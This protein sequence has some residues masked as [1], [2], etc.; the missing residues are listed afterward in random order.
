MIPQT[1]DLKPWVGYIS[2]LHPDLTE[3]FLNDAAQIYPYQRAHQYCCLVILP[4]FWQ[5]AINSIAHHIERPSP[6]GTQKG[7]RHALEAPPEYCLSSA[8]RI[9]LMSSVARTT[10]HGIH[11]DY[12]KQK[13]KNQSFEHWFEHNSLF[14]ETENEDFRELLRLTY[15]LCSHHRR[16]NRSKEQPTMP[17]IHN[18]VTGKRFILKLD[19]VP[20]ASPAWLQFILHPPHLKPLV[21][22]KMD[23][24]TSGAR[25]QKADWLIAAN[26]DLSTRLY[27]QTQ[28]PEELTIPSAYPLPEVAKSA[29]LIYHSYKE[30]IEETNK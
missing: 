23:A 2:T 10:Y 29:H 20:C 8:R 18:Q 3:S 13:E 27:V 25:E 19:S 16:K 1:T 4:D 26:A 30:K 15:Q 14:W 24:Q 28:Y 5:K 6:A 21:S 11:L 17:V 7:Q 22:L 12:L 9:V